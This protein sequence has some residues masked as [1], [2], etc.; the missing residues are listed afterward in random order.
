MCQKS[1]FF[2]S[3]KGTKIC[4]FLNAESAKMSKLYQ[5]VLPNKKVQR[6]TKKTQKV[7]KKTPNKVGIHS[8][9]ATIRKLGDIKCLPCG[10]FFY[11]C[12]TAYFISGQMVVA[13][14]VFSRL[15]LLCR[16]KQ[17]KQNLNANYDQDIFINK[18]VTIIAS[19]ISY[20]K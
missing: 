9:C 15:K 7:T 12:N 5:K 14:L 10:S 6:K 3:Q 1:N 19:F 20:I 18:N 2:F 16:L 8:I 4:F 11:F 17:S 13:H